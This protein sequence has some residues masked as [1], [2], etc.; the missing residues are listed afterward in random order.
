MDLVLPRTAFTFATEFMVFNNFFNDLASF[1]DSFGF[2][3][4]FCF[5]STTVLCCLFF[6]LLDCLLK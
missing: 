5:Y 6:S 2:P 3:P 1:S 4:V